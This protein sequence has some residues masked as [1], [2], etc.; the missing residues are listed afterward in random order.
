MRDALALARRLVG[1]SREAEGLVLLG[2]L[3]L[4]TAAEDA[5]PHFRAALPLASE[6]GMRLL[7]ARSHLGLGTLR[8]RLGQRDAAREHL[9]V[10]AMML[11]EMEMRFWL[12]GAEARLRAVG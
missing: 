9:G 10:A 5:G 7:V 1:R 12:D 3:A 11:R 2:E 6:L 8:E 4:D